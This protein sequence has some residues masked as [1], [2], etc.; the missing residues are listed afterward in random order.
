M[1]ELCLIGG[2][3]TKNLANLVYGTDSYS[4]RDEKENDVHGINVFIGNG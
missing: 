2:C 3:K 4:K 1:F